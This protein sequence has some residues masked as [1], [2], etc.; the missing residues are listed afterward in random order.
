MEKQIERMKGAMDSTPD[1]AAKES[2]HDGKQNIIV[3]GQQID[4][5]VEFKVI[6]FDDTMQDLWFLKS[7]AGSPKGWYDPTDSATAGSI[8]CLAGEFPNP[9][10]P[11]ILY[12]IIFI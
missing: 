2:L 4:K 6:R 5:D 8:S 10:N 7:P 9:E 12:P 1:L 11:F 3:A